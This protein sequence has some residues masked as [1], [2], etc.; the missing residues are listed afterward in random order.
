[1]IVDLDTMR[2]ALTKLLDHV[3]AMGGKN[4]EL[5][6]DLY[7]SIQKRELNDPTKQPSDLTLGSI[8]DDL[9]NVSEVARGT[10]EAVGY[11]LVWAASILRAIGDK[12]P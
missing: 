6:D 5:D 1:M 4:V 8:D 10:K 11:D 12:T 3:E 9:E 7:W 2:A